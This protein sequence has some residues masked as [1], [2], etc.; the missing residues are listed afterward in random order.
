MNQEVLDYIS[1]QCD[2]VSRM[3]DVDDLSRH[4]CGRK[5]L[6][7]GGERWTERVHV[8]VRRRIHDNDLD[9]EIL[10]A[11]RSKI[12]FRDG[13]EIDF[14][15]GD[16]ASR[17]AGRHWHVVFA[18]PFMASKTS[19][20]GAMPVWRIPARADWN[21]LSD[22]GEDALEFLRT[23]EGEVVFDFR[24]NRY[25]VPYGCDYCVLLGSV[26]PSYVDH[27]PFTFGFSGSAELYSP[28]VS[29]AY[30]GISRTPAPQIAEA[31]M[32]QA[33]SARAAAQA[34][35]MMALPSA[36]GL[37]QQSEGAMQQLIESSR[38]RLYDEIYR[39]SPAL[40]PLGM[41]HWSPSDPLEFPTPQ[42]M[43]T[44]FQQQRYAH[45]SE[46]GTWPTQT[47]TARELDLQRRL[48]TV[49][50]ILFGRD[51]G[52]SLTLASVTVLDARQRVDPS[53]TRRISAVEANLLDEALDLEQAAP[54]QDLDSYVYRYEF[55]NGQALKV[56]DKLEC[57]TILDAAARPVRKFRLVE[58]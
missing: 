56:N 24:S 53:R 33:I 57:G 17:F 5:I 9:A 6:V 10:A 21:D 31:A 3:W 26:I 54:V 23:H 42:D 38:Q 18:E 39:A 48:D 35:T 2:T 12:E 58:E 19:A 37:Q 45:I 32:Q 41:V 29:N 46:L 7:C 14:I 55:V 15:A 8:N 20:P 49:R 34:A 13:T 47:P 44:P 50:R 25:K 43:R 51:G 30:A 27:Q 4:I 16:Q 52:D 1:A 36:A 22:A 40:D 28:T 11:R